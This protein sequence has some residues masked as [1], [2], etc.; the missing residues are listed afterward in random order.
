MVITNATQLQNVLAAKI[1]QGLASTQEQ[2]HS[3]VQEHI[4]EFY[5]DYEPRKYQR[6]EAFKESLEKTKI[7]RVGNSLSCAVQLDR[8]YLSHDYP[9][10]P[11]FEHEEG[12]MPATGWQV[13]TWANDATYKKTHGGT[14]ASPNKIRWWNDALEDIDGKRGVR[15]MMKE[16][17]K[18]VGVP[19]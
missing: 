7:E 5:Q 14:V 18:A 6:T 17:L 12:N 16:N 19:I 8:D 3:I 11:Q 15:K 13:A 4:D 2:I 9:S 1:Q 10:T